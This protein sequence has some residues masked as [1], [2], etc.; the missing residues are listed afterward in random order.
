M[1]RYCKKVNRH[2]LEYKV[3]TG[4]LEVSFPTIKANSSYNGSLDFHKVFFP[5]L[6]ICW[7][8]CDNVSGLD[9]QFSPGCMKGHYEGKNANRDIHVTNTKEQVQPGRG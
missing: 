5:D 6:I 8:A 3:S 9:Q 2:L 7:A 1:E 4:L